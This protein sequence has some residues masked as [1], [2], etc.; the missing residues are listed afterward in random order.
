MKPKRE[1]E[2][3]VEKSEEKSEEKSLN[4]YMDHDQGH[5]SNIGISALTSEDKKV[6]ALL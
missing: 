1:S 6:S 5:R 4:S 3:A 2:I